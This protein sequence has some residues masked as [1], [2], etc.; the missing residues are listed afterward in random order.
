MKNARGL[1]LSLI[2]YKNLFIVNDER[3]WIAISLQL[4]CT[5]DES[6]VHTRRTLTIFT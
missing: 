5:R 1:R 6:G 4:D 3:I 2:N